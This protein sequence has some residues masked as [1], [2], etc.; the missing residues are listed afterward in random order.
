MIAIF[1]IIFLLALAVLLSTNRKAINIR[2]V[3]SAF[4]IQLAFAAFALYFEFGQAVMAGLSS[5]VHSIIQYSNAGIE[6]IF[7]SL[8]KPQTIGFIFLFHVLPVII[9]MSALMSVLYHLRI[10]QW[11]A[12]I[13]GGGLAKATGASKVETLGAA[14]NIFVSQTEAPVVI[15]PYLKS[16][17]D[18]QFFTLM[19]VGMASVAGS[20][21]VGYAAMGIPLTYLIA[22]AFMS[23]PGGLLMA[24]II[25][26]AT[27]VASKTDEDI[28]ILNIDLADEDGNK[29]SNVIE[30]AADG[31]SIGLKL[32]GNIGAMLLAFV[33][34]IALMNGILGYVGGLAGFEG[35][36]FEGILGTIFSPLMYILGIDWAEA[37]L[38]GNL[39][40]QKLILNEF[41]AFSNM[42]TLLDQMNPHTLAVVTFALCGFANFS[43]LAIQLGG[44]GALAPER[45]AFI[46]KVGM[47]ALAAGT[48]S[49][50]MS[51]ALASLMLSFAQTG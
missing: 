32:A 15:R 31:A 33:A 41:V 44:L 36:T 21:L 23:A 37:E 26:P 51:A 9:F 39:V 50:L 18:D 2:T 48:L 3:G 40:G 6:F 22:A 10:M 42:T 1:G 30:A 38:A 11:I 24:K 29:P 28:D 19:V 20:V 45:K 5:A 17:K 12:M 27:D 8:G 14:S 4:A 46:A 34:L 13:I 49:N 35:L 25:M 47:R 7:G 16:L 43:S